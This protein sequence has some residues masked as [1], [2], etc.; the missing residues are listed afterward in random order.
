MIAALGVLGGL[1]APQRADH[2]ITEGVA[3]AEQGHE[4]HRRPLTTPADQQLERLQLGNGCS[5]WPGRGTG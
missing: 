5:C 4:R 3:G 2:V 1:Q